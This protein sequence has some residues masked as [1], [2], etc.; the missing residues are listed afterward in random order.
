MQIRQKLTF[1]FVV[2]VA[3]ILAAFSLSIYYISAEYR[4]S[5]FY[6][7]L[8]SKATNVATLLIKVDEIDAALLQR[9]EKDNPISLPEE[10]I[11]IYDYQNQ[12]VY[13]SNDGQ[14]IPVE[15]GFLDNIRIN[16]NIRYR[17][18]NTE[19]LGMLYAGSTDRFVIVAKAR[20]IYGFKRLQ[21][22][23]TILW[24][25]FGISI[26]LILAAGNIF[27]R[28][29]LVPIKRIIRQVSHIGI[30]N[31]DSRVETSTEKKDEIVQLA[32][33]FN[34]MLD[35]LETAF[36][37]QSE[38]IANASHELRTP[39][40]SI[41]GNTEVLL[42]VDRENITYKTALVSILDDMK[43]LNQLINKLLIL[44]QAGSV[45]TEKNLQTIRVDEQLW[46][47]RSEV[48]KRRKD[49]VVLMHF[50]PDLQEEHLWVTGNE[51]LIKAVFLNLMEN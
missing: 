48:L 39:L 6:E 42:L 45:Q 5:S 24:I 41:T 1:S 34:H 9:I 2:L 19:L 18:G 23:R 4:K 14:P 37:L 36:H 20:D 10:Q 13:S 32:E 25:A 27:A 44:A 40:T 8:E 51:L 35:R 46:T 38:F 49:N 11:D 22:L 30:H 21:N 43:E 17:S 28:R 29:A 12:I 33:A 7:R 16:T 15:N 26:L 50:S 3:V 47:A 31:L